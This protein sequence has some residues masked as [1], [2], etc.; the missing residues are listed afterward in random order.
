MPAD[1][2]LLVFST[3]P[4]TESARRISEQLITGRF[5]ACANVVAPIH[6]VYRWEGK[7]EHADETLVLFKLPAASFPSFE[8]QLRTLHPYDVPE[9]IATNIADGS[10]KY[11]RWVID[12]CT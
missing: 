12:S 3:F 5:A 7:V 10:E 1:A 9:I 8:A 11:L 2:V 4:D 6:S